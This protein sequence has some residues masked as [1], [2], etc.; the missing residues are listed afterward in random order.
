MH[1][2]IS[3]EN[4]TGTR[5]AHCAV[6]VPRSQHNTG[7]ASKATSHM[8]SVSAPQPIVTRGRQA[9]VQR[10][11]AAARHRATRRAA[12][13]PPP[14]SPGG[15]GERAPP[16]PRRRAALGPM[17][18]GNFATSAGGEREK[19]GMRVSEARGLSV[20]VCVAECRCRVW[21]GEEGGQVPWQCWMWLRA[22]WGR[23]GPAT[24]P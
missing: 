8:H 11:A 3:A 5:S 19:G 13:S 22:E 14:F 18:Y 21:L 15:E 6:F 2:I 1:E 4:R 9:V 16:P 12:S 17:P 20:C 7:A 23:G 24:G 10:R